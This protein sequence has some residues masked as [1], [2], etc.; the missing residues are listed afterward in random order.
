MSKRLIFHIDVN[1]AYLSWTAAYLLDKGYKIDIRNI[2][3][4]I[5]GN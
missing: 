4:V 3:S 1:S 2:P 5:G